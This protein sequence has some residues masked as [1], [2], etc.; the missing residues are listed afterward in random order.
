[1]K[2]KNRLNTHLLC[3]RPFFVVQSA[4]YGIGIINIVVKRFGNYAVIIVDKYIVDS[5]CI[6]YIFVFADVGIPFTNGCRSE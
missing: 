1:M 3:G 6:W 4:Q 5:C 2:K